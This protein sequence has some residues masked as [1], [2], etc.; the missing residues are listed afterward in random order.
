MKKRQAEAISAAGSTA[1]VLARMRPAGGR[2]SRARRT[3]DRLSEV[4]ATSNWACGGCR[5][6]DLVL[7]GEDQNT[8]EDDSWA[9]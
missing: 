5:V 9:L 8:K 3:V 6:F 7:G 1:D 2:A 4:L